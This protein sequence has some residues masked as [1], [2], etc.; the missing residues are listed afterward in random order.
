MSIHETWETSIDDL[1]SEPGALEV[2]A[3]LRRRMRAGD[4]KPIVDVVTQRWRGTYDLYVA[5]GFGQIYAGICARR[6]TITPISLNATPSEDAPIEKNQAKL[7]GLPSPFK[8]TLRPGKE[9]DDGNLAWDET[10]FIGEH[11]LDPKSVPL[12]VGY[13]RPL[14]TLWHLHHERGL[15]RWPYGHEKLWLLLSLVP[16]VL[17]PLLKKL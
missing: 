13:T 15:A 16:T 6:I 3:N 11:T 4:F 8:A 12:E 9:D 10:I 1:L 5:Y 14:T 7:A 17:P 2:Y